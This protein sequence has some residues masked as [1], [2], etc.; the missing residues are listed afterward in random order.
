MGYDVICMLKKAKTKYL[1]E[2]GRSMTVK[3]IFSSSKKRRGRSR[4]LLSTVVTLPDSSQKARLVFVRNRS[5][6]KDWLVLLSTDLE[7]S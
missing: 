7:L 2:E 1:T 6:R 5:N 4:Y 3:S